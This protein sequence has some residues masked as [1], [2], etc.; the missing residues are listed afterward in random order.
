MFVGDYELAAEMS[1]GNHGVFYRAVAPSRLGLDDPYV[2]VKVLGPTASDDDF[3]RISNELRLLHSL[4]SDYLVELLDAGSANGELFIVTRYYPAGPAGASSDLDRGGALRL[5]ADVARGAHALH[6]VGV[7]HR[8][9]TPQTVLIDDGRGRLADLG[10][11]TMLTDK[12]VGIGPIGSLE[13][14]DPAL[15]SG[16][17][18]GR[19]S[20][21]WSLGVTLHSLLTGDGVY[22]ALPTTSILDACRHMLHTPMQLAGDLHESDRLAIERALSSTDRWPTAL[23]FAE[24]LEGLLE[25]ERVEDD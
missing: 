1:A 14:A 15:M 23:A 17:T 16:A 22:G 8:D 4:N 19:S 2:A 20:D 21:V 6:E 10:L 25:L 11:A 18:A 3:R 7:A 9:I 12:T 24:H 5:V 13:F